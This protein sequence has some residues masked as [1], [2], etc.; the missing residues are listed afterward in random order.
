M[1]KV[2]ID[3]KDPIDDSE[4]W[5]LLERQRIND[6]TLLC[7]FNPD[8]GKISVSLFH[9]FEQ[10][11]DLSKRATLSQWGYMTH[12]VDHINTEMEATQI[13]NQFLQD[14]EHNN[15]WWEGPAKVPTNH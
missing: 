14:F 15:H 13:V 9:S 4:G 10:P 3:L 2:V 8:T 11:N 1:K 7:W 6:R 12:F 5:L